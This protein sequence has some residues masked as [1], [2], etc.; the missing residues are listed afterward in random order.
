MSNLRALYQ[1]NPL[2]QA[3]YN[4]AYSYFTYYEE[5]YNRT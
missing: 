4:A 5:I 1:L 3:G 2:K